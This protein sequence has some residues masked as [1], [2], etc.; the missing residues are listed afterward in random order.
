MIEL[1]S[2][3]R[4]EKSD[5][6]ARLKD[7]IAKRASAQ[8]LGALQQALESTTS[9]LGAI[10]DLD[11]GYYTSNYLMMTKRNELLGMGIP[12]GL[13]PLE[14]SYREDYFGLQRKSTSFVILQTAKEKLD[15]YLELVGL[16][17]LLWMVVAL[18][19]SWVEE[20][21]RRFTYYS[22]QNKYVPMVSYFFVAVA[23]WVGPALAL[24]LV[25]GALQDNGPKFVVLPLTISFLVPLGIAVDQLSRVYTDLRYK[26]N[27]AEDLMRVLFV[28]YL[29]MAPF[30]FRGLTR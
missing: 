14:D 7:A 24:G 12:Q 4:A 10:A 23:L 26:R 18:L 11:T 3:L 17:G 28:G 13:G 5:L 16:C 21:D 25:Y 8:A 9:L 30:I 6:E 15:P 27:F 20:L 29:V 22:R 2:K 1:R 19:M